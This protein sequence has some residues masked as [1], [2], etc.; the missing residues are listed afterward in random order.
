MTEGNIVCE[1]LEKAL[2][3]L[4]SKGI[5]I[6]VCYPGFEHGFKE[7]QMIED[8]VLKLPSKS[9]DVFRFQLVNR[10]SAPYILGIEKH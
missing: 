5:I 9:Y 1:T 2:L 6:L 8:Y 3:Y 10:Q 4:E 7:A